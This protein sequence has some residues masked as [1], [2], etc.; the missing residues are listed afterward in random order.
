MPYKWILIKDKLD[1]VKLFLSTSPLT[2]PSRSQ[3]KGLLF[4]A[5]CFL[6]ELTYIQQLSWGKSTVKWHISF[7]TM[8]A[9]QGFWGTCWGTLLTR[10]HLS[11][12]N[13]EESCCLMCII[14]LLLGRVRFFSLELEFLMKSTLSSKNFL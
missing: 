13:M 10:P 11:H 8:K 3:I 14:L 4:V 9:R 12:N 6:L 7:T 2:Q 1:N 5:K